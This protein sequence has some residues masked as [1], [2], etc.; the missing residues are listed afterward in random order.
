MRKMLSD[1]RGVT[2]IE[3]GLLAAA[4]AMA[5]LAVLRMPAESLGQVFAHMGGGNSNTGSYAPD[6]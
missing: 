5:L 1:R 2:S 3:Y 4:L 6:R